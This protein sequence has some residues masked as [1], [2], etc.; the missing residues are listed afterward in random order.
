M[1]APRNSFPR[2]SVHDIRIVNSLPSGCPLAEAVPSAAVEDAKN[3]AFSLIAPNGGGHLD[4]VRLQVGAS[5]LDRIRIC[6]A[7]IARLA[8]HPAVCALRR[9]ARAA[10]EV[11]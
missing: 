3:R 11:G 9:S 4:L 1:I 5:G 8:G 6:E 7:C 2:C 10:L